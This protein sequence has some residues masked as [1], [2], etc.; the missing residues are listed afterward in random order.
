MARPT[1][2]SRAAAAAAAPAVA[3]SPTPEEAPQSPEA[4][5]V[6][7]METEV[8]VEE[9]GRA[10]E[11]T[12]QARGPG[13]GAGGLALKFTDPLSWKA[14]KPIA[15]A[16]LIKRLKALSAELTE[17]EQE[18]V[19]RES[20]AT[21]AKELVGVGLLQHKDKGVRAYAACCL[22]D[23]LRLHAPDAPYT[24][25]QLRDIFQLFITQLRGL[26]DPETS[27][28][29]QYLYLLDSLSSVKSVVL[30]SDIPSG[31]QITLQIFTS[32][33]DLAKPDGPK[34]VEYHMTD[35]LVQ[36]IDECSTLPAEVIDIIVAQFL[37]AVPGAVQSL[38]KRK[39][40]DGREKGGGGGKEEDARQTKLI[41]NLPPPAYNMAKTICNSCVDKM[42]RHICQYFTDVMVGASPS[43]TSAEK[44]RKTSG[45]QSS[46]SAEPESE[47]EGAGGAAGGLHEPNHEDMHE[48]HKAHLLVKE[49]WK[50]CPQVLQNVIPQLEQELLVDNVEIRELATETIGEMALSGN[51]GS[52]APATWKVWMGRAND[53]SAAVRGIWVERAV[54][55]L[56][57]RNDHMAVQLVDLIAGK[58]SDMDDRVRN[59]AC[60]ALLTLD[61]LSITTKLGSESSPFNTYDSSEKDQGFANVVGGRRR[62]AADTEA[63]ST[64]GWGKKILL[65]LGERARDKKISVRFEGMRCLARMW[66]MAYNDIASGNEVITKQLGWIPSKILDTFYI[67]DPEVNCLLDHVLHE[68][69]IP[70]NFPP[71][72]K[73]ERKEKE[74]ANGKGKEK[75]GEREK[76]KEKEQLEGDRIRV[77][78]LLVL[79]NGLESKPKKALFAVP[80]KQISYAKVMD[81]YLKYCEDYNGGVIKEGLD[82]KTV[83]YSLSKYADWLSQKL[84]DAAEARENLWRFAKLHDRRCYQLIRFC[85][86][87]DS[88]YRTVVKALKEIKKRIGD[89]PGT[90]PS[91]LKTLTP[92]LY[93]LSNLIYNKSHVLPIVEFSRTNDKGLGNVAR[94]VL[95][96]ISTSNP[97]VFKANVK[98]LVDLLQEQ[99]RNGVKGAPNNGAVNT[100]RTTASFAKS[101]PAD[102]P[103]DRM[104]MQNL[105]SYALTG[106]PPAAAKHAVSI[107]MWSSNRKEMYAVDLLRRCIKDF[108]FGEENFLAKLACLG[109][110]VLLAP[111]QSED[112]VDKVIDIARDVLMKSRRQEGG[113]DQDEKD[114]VDDE[115]LADECKAKLLALR[116]LVNRL[117]AHID[118][119]SVKNIAAPVMKLLVTLI[120]NEGELSKAKD[121]PKSHR[122]R[123]R[124]AAAQFLLKLAHHKVYDE[125]ITPTDFNRL[126]CV[127]Q[128][129]C[130]NVRKGF[131]D[132]VKRYL[133]ANKL[134]PRFYTVIFLMAYE[135]EEDMKE[136]AIT[137]IK[138]R[139][140]M[141]RQM[142][143]HHERMEKEEEGGGGAGGVVRGQ[144][145][146]EGVF[147]R[148]LSL[149]AH[150]PDFGTQVED[151]ADFAKYILFYLKAVATEE[152]LSLIYYVA[153]RVKQFRDGIT[154]ENSEN[155]YYLSELSQAVIRRYGDYHH[156]TIQTW[157]GKLRLPAGLFAP[158]PSP[159]ISLEVARKTY[160]PAEID[161]KLDGLIKPRR[162]AA[163]GP[164]K[165]KSESKGIAT[166]AKKKK[167]A[168]EGTV[169]MAVGTEREKR[170]VGR[171]MKVRTEERRRSGRV[172]VKPKYVEEVESEEEMDVDRSESEVEEPAEEEEREEGEEKRKGEN[173]R[174]QGGKK[175]GVKRGPGRP[176]KSDKIGN[177]GGGRN[178]KEVVSVE[179]GDSDS[180]DLSDPPDTDEDM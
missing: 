52:S 48:L 164:K 145:V 69:L 127:V 156:W 44:K 111:D 43:S 82:E 13:E 123:L 74:N 142:Q 97:A 10:D 115:H 27:Y 61:Y 78:R 126:A 177:G 33:F 2:S 71:I 19:D 68:K 147:A 148:L 173:R 149:L 96:E 125:L 93:R 133:A 116:I 83:K 138:A 136:E 54:D 150:H 36:L 3:K 89:A 65:S 15:V 117:R 70:V 151:L 73:L 158:M 109:Q 80:I 53:R 141:L 50:A 139:A 60:K 67:N 121:T 95:K 105:V 85:Y 122:S 26:A 161:V 84:P 159:E 176:R 165:R 79:V 75:E 168:R 91:I 128:D 64:K 118:P 21:P 160:L 18:D 175:E 41:G 5:P 35:I 135:P 24:A 131:I 87:P 31:D 143:R 45:R 98:A 157:P 17:L 137:W 51:F 163:T 104:L 102:I 107:I 154:P 20:L 146:M 8:D 37:R 179:S 152:N 42:A 108:K 86:S 22:A 172:G 11:D 130:Y 46:L 14:G 166:P 66:D 57:E 99:S 30:I 59:T 47:D 178:G 6:E 134:A 92:L 94:E 4:P 155:L 174:K 153:Q 113:D 55:I 103:Q 169:T 76:E 40:G 81:A 124:L 140:A 77:E 1:R 32:F 144:N 58:L 132:K 12:E 39:R 23:M 63:E 129:H 72:E 114:W 49:L 62:K 106:R 28:Y 25:V 56:K 101:Y 171:P 9:E 167:T 100:L 90:A 180:S 170:A 34:N 38:E 7:E 162:P 29:Q 112:E 120:A 119:E 88:D 16:T 110:L